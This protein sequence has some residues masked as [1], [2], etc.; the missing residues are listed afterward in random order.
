MKIGNVFNVF[1]LSNPLYRGMAEKIILIGSGIC[2]LVFSWKMLAI[3]PLSNIL[4]AI[5]IILAFSFH[6]WAEKNHRQAHKKSQDIEILVTAGVYSKIRHPLY[7]SLIL[8]N[9][10]I[11][12]AFGVMITFVLALLTI[13][14]WIVTALTEE[15]ALLHTFPHEYL[16]YKQKVRWRMIP[17]VF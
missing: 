1:F 2:G 7:L 16:Q 4:G 8:Q 15:A 12:L 17:G 14:H 6:R 9:I 3:F 10:G 13:I 11:A 5:L